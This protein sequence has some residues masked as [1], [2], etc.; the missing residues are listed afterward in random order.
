MPDTS[1]RIE[2]AAPPFPEGAQMNPSQ[3]A[4]WLVENISFTATGAFLGGQIGGARPTSDVGLF[5][6]GRRIEVF[7]NGKYRSLLAVPIGAMMP[8]PSSLLSLPDEDYQFCNGQLLLKNDFPD[9]AAVLGD[10]W[11]SLGDD[12]T[13]FRLPD[14]V[15]RVPVGVGTGNYNPKKDPSI[16]IGGL[17][18][19]ATGEY[20]GSEWPTYRQTT[21][22]AGVTPR[23]YYAPYPNGTNREFFTGISQPSFVTP[24]II[25][26]K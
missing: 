11:K 20:Y 21:P 1:I 4:Q 24:W 18:K 13:F 22:D 16:K 8:W 17:T 26:A 14:T 15:G 19:R 5:I 25:R 10:T 7:N 9:L 2:L 12:S 3:F 23:Y 6:N